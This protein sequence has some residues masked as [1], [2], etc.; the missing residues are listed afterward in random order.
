MNARARYLLSPWF[1]GALFLLI[2]NDLWWKAAYSNT[3]TGKLSDFSGVLVL[4]LLFNFFSERNR[5]L[6]ALFVIVFFT[7][8]KSPLSEGLIVTWNSLGLF[9]IARVVDYSDLWALV[10]LPIVSHLPFPERTFRPAQLGVLLS[11]TA[12][13]LASTSRASSYRMTGWE[14]KSYRQVLSFRIQ[15]TPEEF[16]KLAEQ[17]FQL[18]AVPGDSVYFEGV[19][20]PVWFFAYQGDADLPLIDSAEMIVLPHSEKILQVHVISAWLHPGQSALKI[21]R[22]KDLKMEY[23]LRKIRTWEAQVQP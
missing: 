9:S 3:L 16:M 7:F 2:C 17:E 13:A 19:R 1:T 18:A 21:F 20:S 6:N 23:A 10:L 11:C 15:R 5:S 14:Y 8:W 4:G 22:L 12:F